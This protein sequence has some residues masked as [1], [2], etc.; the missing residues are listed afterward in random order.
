MTSSVLI[1]KNY[2][3]LTAQL[4][5]LTL[6]PSHSF[7]FIII[8]IQLLTS[9]MCAVYSTSGRWSGLIFASKEQWL[10]IFTHTLSTKINKIIWNHIVSLNI[11]KNKKAFRFYSNINLAAYS[12]LYSYF[13]LNVVIVTQHNCNIQVWNNMRN[14]TLL[15]HCLAREARGGRMCKTK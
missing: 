11:K 2:S 3:L 8:P 5:K 4:I 14:N 7:I 9:S 13:F 15:L 6:S 12:N 1:Y 10:L